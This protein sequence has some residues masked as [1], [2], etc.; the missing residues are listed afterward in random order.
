MK[1]ILK[2]KTMIGFIVV[3]LSL[4]IYGTR[5]PEVTNSLDTNENIESVYNI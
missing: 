2:S 3:V 1:E 5:K 4:T